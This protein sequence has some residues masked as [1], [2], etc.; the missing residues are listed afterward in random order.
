V[1]AQKKMAEIKTRIILRNDTAKNWSE[2]DAKLTEGLVLYKGEIGVEF[3]PSAESL[4]KQTRIKIG[5]GITR[6]SELP[7][8]EQ[9]LSSYYNKEEVNKAIEEAIK[10]IPATDLSNYYTKSEV[11]AL[12]PTIKVNNAV[13]ADSADSASDAEKLGGQEAS[14]YASAEALS[15]HIDNQNNPHNVTAEQ[16]GAYTKGE[17]DS[18]ISGVTIDNLDADKVTFDKDLVF[19]KTFGKYVPDKTSGSVT[20]PTATE[21]MSLKDLLLNAFSE[22]TKPSKTDPAVSFSSVA[23][24]SKEVGTEVTLSYTASLS[25]GSYTYGPETGITATGWEVSVANIEG[26]EKLTSSSSNFGKVTVKDGD[27][28]K[29]KITA[30]ATHGAGSMPVTNLGNEYA[31]A[32]IAAGSKSKTS[33]G[34]TGYRAWFHC[35]RPGGSLIDVDSITSDTIRNNIGSDT[36]TKWVSKN[37]SFTSSLSTTNMQQIF[38]A[39]PAGVVKGVSVAHSV[40]GAPQTVNKKTIYVKGNGNYVTDDAPNGM[41]YDLYYVSNDNPNDGAATYTITVTK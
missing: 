1:E 30:K 27:S 41:A 38:F 14:Y 9:D 7:Y 24:G 2:E 21:N 15:G 8:I 40:N 23:E 4:N 28:A 22:E 32:Q 19:T 10:A 20:I 36:K 3:N 29:Y 34:L 31:G 33:S 26:A 35:Y 12:I 37:G 6:W 39:A 11:D 18:L 13:H 5:D 17:V 16:V 25:A